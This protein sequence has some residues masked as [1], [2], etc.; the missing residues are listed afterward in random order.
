MKKTELALI[1][2]SLLV[3][4]L[5]LFHIPGSE[6]SLALVL[7]LISFLYFYFGFALFNNIRL[8]E[9]FKKASYKKVK[10]N[11]ISGGIVVGI[12]LSFSALGILFKF[13]SLPG[14]LPQLS[15]GLLLLGIVSLVYIVKNIK[16]KEA[17]Y[18]KILKRTLL[19][20]TIAF[21]LIMI[22]S[23]TWLNWKYPDHPEYVKAILKA[24]AD[25]GNEE[26]WEK[27]EEERKKMNEK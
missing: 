1:A 11:R 21:V 4:I 13:L 20:G 24:E 9:I 3:L 25:A 7:T 17:Y 10:S 15:I 27:V 8:R 16:S 23:K 5:N 14:A 26:L 22:P 6:A 12:A 19:F 2:L 18:S